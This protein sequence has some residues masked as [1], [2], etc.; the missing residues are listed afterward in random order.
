MADAP[1]AYDRYRV[2]ANPYA[3]IE[4]V[5]WL[6]YGRLGRGLPTCLQGDGGVG[7]GLI[8][9][10]IAARIT[11]GE[12]IFPGGQANE[13]GNV[14][15][16]G[17][18]DLFRQVHLPRLVVA[19]ADVEHRIAFPKPLPLGPGGTL[20]R[21]MF[22]DD[23]PE[24]RAMFETVRPILLTLDPLI[25]L[26]NPKLSFNNAQH[27]EE[28]F[29]PVFDVCEEYGTIPL[30]AQHFNKN[31]SGPAAYRGVGSERIV[32]MARI[33]LGVGPDPDNP[34]KYHIAGG[35]TNFDPPPTVVYRIE[36]APFR[37][38]NFPDPRDNNKIAWVVMEGVSEASYADV[39]S[40][41]STK[42]AEESQGATFLTGALAG[43]ARQW[44]DLVEE[45]KEAGFAVAAL[46]RARDEVGCVQERVG[47]G[48]DGKVWWRLPHSSN[49]H[50]DEPIPEK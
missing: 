28:A 50:R 18:E 3:E 42:P 16:M 44:K 35:K 37:Q 8:L 15:P 1:T 39:V 9:T 34:G 12:P 49:G 46:T 13:P 25:A 32:N 27:V 23:V 43:G 10:H 7:K 6:D 26:M 20:R 17:S 2:V 47:F 5:D 41:A 40:G 22:P 31:K 36:R 29:A 21:W 11:R 38:F 4:P 45:G 24:L 33:V 30:Y 48:K 19:G 14:V